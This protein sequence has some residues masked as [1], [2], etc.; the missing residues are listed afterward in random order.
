MLS[1]LDSASPATNMRSQRN[2]QV[3]LRGRVMCNAKP[4]MSKDPIVSNGRLHGQYVPAWFATK[5][6]H[7][8]V[9][10]GRVQHSLHEPHGNIHRRLPV[11]VLPCQCHVM[12]SFLPSTP[13][14]SQC[15]GNVL[16]LPKGRLSR[17]SLPWNRCPMDTRETSFVAL[18]SSLVLPSLFCRLCYFAVFCCSPSTSLT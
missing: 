18:P 10:R 5:P 3:G 17:L 4:I 9:I 6:F 16:G 1:D 11:I 14:P 7:G 12:K 15:V 8:F 13:F 2:L